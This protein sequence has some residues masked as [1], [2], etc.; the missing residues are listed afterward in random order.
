V[1]SVCYALLLLLALPLKAEMELKA[2]QTVD[3]YGS[4]ALE[5]S[6]ADVDYRLSWQLSGQQGEAGCLPAQV[7][8]SMTATVTEPLEWP[9]T[10]EWQNYRLALTGYERLVRERALLA[11]EWLER[12]LFEIAPQPGCDQLR[13]VADNIGHHQLG[14]AQALL[15]DFQRQHDY[16][17]NLGLIRPA[18]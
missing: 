5:P 2:R 15:R 16:G 17:R 4:S 6:L 3:I 12:S 13:R 18:E 7:L 9:Q 8:V 1:K 11:A 14:I 10:P